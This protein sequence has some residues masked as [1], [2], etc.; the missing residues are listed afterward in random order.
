MV[1]GVNELVSKNS[2]T[3]L[4]SRTLL[5]ERIEQ[6]RP[7]VWNDQGVD[8]LLKVLEPPKKSV[9]SWG[10]KPLP[11]SWNRPGPSERPGL[12][13]AAKAEYA[14]QV[15]HFKQAKLMPGFLVAVNNM[16]ADVRAKALEFQRQVGG[17]LEAAVNTI[18]NKATYQVQAKTKAGVHVLLLTLKDE[19]T[20]SKS[21]QA[22]EL[23]RGLV[24]GAVVKWH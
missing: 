24:T 7:E 12:M 22:L 1:A 5:G 10:E 21:P 19:P 13:Q 17:V 8:A 4:P 11:S 16:P 9:S 15:A 18:Q 20:T 14:D 3:G 6:A 2:L 23:G